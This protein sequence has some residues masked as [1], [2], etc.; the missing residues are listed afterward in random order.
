MLLLINN[1]ERVKLCAAAVGARM[2]VHIETVYA[3]VL[4]AES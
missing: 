4:K 3:T 2:S 1:I